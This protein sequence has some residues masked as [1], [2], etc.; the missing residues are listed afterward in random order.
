[1]QSTL[2]QIN[3]KRRTAARNCSVLMQLNI[4]QGD[5]QNDESTNQS[6]SEL[7]TDLIQEKKALVGSAI[8]SREFPLTLKD[9]ADF[10]TA[11]N[12]V[13]QEFLICDTAHPR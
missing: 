5:S 7:E 8:M 3:R 6:H 12:V 9:D 13:R 10:N 1:M 11:I 4:I 2:S